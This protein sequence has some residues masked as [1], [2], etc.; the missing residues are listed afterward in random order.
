MFENFVVSELL[1]NRFNNG[2]QD[3]LFYFR[4]NKGQEVD[5]VLDYGIKQKIMEIKSG[6]TIATSFFKGLKY[7]S[8][9]SGEVEQAYLVYGGDVV[10]MQEGVNVMGWLDIDT[11]AV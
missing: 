10:R 3:N 8:K 2:K 4:N 6:Q 11:I 9:L 5:I 7:F 1:K